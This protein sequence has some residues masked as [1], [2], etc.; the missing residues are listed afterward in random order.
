[1]FFLARI[2]AQFQLS[3]HF[4]QFYF[5]MGS[6]AMFVILELPWYFFQRARNIYKINP[7]GDSLEP[8]LSDFIPNHT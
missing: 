5:E 2:L 7:I 8:F 6:L 4:A 1:M 3:H